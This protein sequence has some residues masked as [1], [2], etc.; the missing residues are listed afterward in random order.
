MKPVYDCFIILGKSGFI[1]LAITFAA[2]RSL[3]LIGL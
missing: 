3:R 1:L 2:I